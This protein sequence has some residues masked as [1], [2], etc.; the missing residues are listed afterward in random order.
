MTQN[1]ATVQELNGSTAQWLNGRFGTQKKKLVPNVR[2]PLP[3]VTR[4]E[5]L[6]LKAA[7]PTPTTKPKPTPTPTPTPKKRFR[8]GGGKLSAGKKDKGGK[9]GTGKDSK[10]D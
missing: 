6:A 8:K 4:S 7:T 10:E 9:K 5:A 2:D 1:D 3:G